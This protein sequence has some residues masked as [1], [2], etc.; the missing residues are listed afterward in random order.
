MDDGRD[1]NLFE[2]DDA[3]YLVLVNEERQYSLW[4]EHLEVP[5]GWRVA[6]PRDTRQACLDFITAVWTDL[7]PYSLQQVRP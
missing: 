7:R 5:G 6:H 4:P 3:A 1:A 2:N